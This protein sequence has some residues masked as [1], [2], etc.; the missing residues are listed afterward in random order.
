MEAFL[1]W[2][3]SWADHPWEEG[4]VQNLHLGR[5]M[6]TG[7]AEEV[8]CSCSLAAVALEQSS[9]AREVEVQVDCKRE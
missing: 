1:S 4:Y 3:G 5:S 8:G 7:K 2:E 6:E 9:V